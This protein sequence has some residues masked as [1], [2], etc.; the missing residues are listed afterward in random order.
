MDK[1]TVEYDLS[2]GIFTGPYDS[3]FLW[4]IKSEDVEDSHKDWFKI[5][6]IVEWNKFNNHIETDECIY[7]P[8]NED[9]EF[10]IS[11]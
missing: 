1:I 8:Y 6:S 7:V 4:L 9:K 5:D 11:I 2:K 10:D 3:I